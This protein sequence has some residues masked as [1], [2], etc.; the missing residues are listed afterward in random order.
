MNETDS[1]SVWEVL[2]ENDSREGRKSTPKAVTSG[3][4][5]ILWVRR[6]L[7]PDSSYHTRIDRV[8]PAKGAKFAPTDSPWNNK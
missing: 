6:R 8:P 3:D 1:L 7:R 4:D 5:G 2:L